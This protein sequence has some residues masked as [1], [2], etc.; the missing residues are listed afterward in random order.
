MRDSATDV[1][2][3]R[4]ALL[5]K[6]A[7]PQDHGSD[8]RVYGLTVLPTPQGPL[9]RVILQLGALSLGECCGQARR[10][11]EFDAPIITLASDETS[12]TSYDEFLAAAGKK[13]LPLDHSFGI[14]VAE[15]EATRMR[16]AVLV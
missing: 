16:A 4:R 11:R 3:L 9:H 5:T 10:D 8:L 1:L 13:A 15:G 2:P 7:S 6:T 14:E 12:F